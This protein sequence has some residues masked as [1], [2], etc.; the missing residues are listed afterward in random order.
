M[1]LKSKVKKSKTFITTFRSFSRYVKGSVKQYPTNELLHLFNQTRSDKGI[2]GHGYARVYHALFNQKRNDVRNFCEIGLLR[3][4]LL[5]L[6]EGTRGERSYEELPSLDVWHQYFPN[7]QII[8][9][10]I[11][12]FEQPISD[13]QT[14]IQG[15]QKERTDLKKITDTSPKPDIIVDDGLHASRHQ[16]ISFSYLF[17]SLQP[18]GYYCIEDLRYKPHE[19]EEE[20]VPKTL[21]LLYELNVTGEWLS[22]L[23]TEKEKRAIESQVKSV[24]FFDSLKYE[25]ANDPL[26]YNNSLAIIEKKAPDSDE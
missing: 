9:F 1:G 8:G 6:Q 20:N 26:K 10:D 14:V 7:A 13:Y 24:C 21:S 11:K 17:D 12:A 23:S 5:H 16:Q 3:N 4:K 18:G 19:Y 22:P 25:Y 15:D 2:P